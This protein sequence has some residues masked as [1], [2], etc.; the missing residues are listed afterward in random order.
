MRYKLFDFVDEYGLQD[1]VTLRP[2]WSRST[3]IVRD[4]LPV[5]TEKTR[6]KY[7]K[8]NDVYLRVKLE[9]LEPKTSQVL[10]IPETS[11]YFNFDFIQHISPIRQLINFHK[12]PASW[13]LKLQSIDHELRTIGNNLIYQ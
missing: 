10:V 1:Y 9:P 3:V 11:K 5:D 2:S 8:V 7:D 12:G 4:G 13:K 6:F